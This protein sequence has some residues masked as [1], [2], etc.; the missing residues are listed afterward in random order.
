M[1]VELCGAAVWRFIF[2]AWKAC[3]I[4]IPA[5][6]ERLTLWSAP[7][8]QLADVNCTPLDALRIAA[9]PHGIAGNLQLILTGFDD[10]LRLPVALPFPVPLPQRRGVRLRHLKRRAWQPA[11]RFG[12][13]LR[14][15]ESAQI[16]RASGR[17]RV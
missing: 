8:A 15:E 7:A 4:G 2:R 9:A 13:A 3:S 12:A 1:Q 10:D 6:G 14:L 11:S 17:E 5:Q 16:G